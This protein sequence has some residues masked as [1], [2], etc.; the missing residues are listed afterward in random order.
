MSRFTAV[1]VLALALAPASC[2]AQ[3]GGMGGMGGMGGEVPDWALAPKEFDVK[4]ETAKGKVVAGKLSLAVV[5]VDCDLGL[6]YLTPSKIKVVRF[7]GPVGLPA[8]EEPEPP[9]PG[10]QP[11]GMGVFVPRAQLGVGVKGVVVTTTGEEV[12]GTV[13]VANW[14]L[15]T[16]L[17]VLSLAPEKLKAVTFAPAKPEPRPATP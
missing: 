8:Q 16:D 2:F 17:G 14:T 15:K 4:V 13:Y 5:P 3:F 7:T 11:P 6:Y 12:S 1:A 10:V 9:V